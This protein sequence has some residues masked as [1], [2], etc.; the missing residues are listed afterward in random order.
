MHLK[1]PHRLA[2]TREDPSKHRLDIDLH[3]VLKGQLPRTD[4]DLLEMAVM[5]IIGTP[6]FESVLEVPTP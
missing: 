4:N 3:A 1:M 2:R 5:P 6:V